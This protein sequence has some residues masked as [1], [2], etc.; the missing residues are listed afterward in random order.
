MT[1]SVGKGR[2]AWPQCIYE[3][4]AVTCHLDE[5][6]TSVNN[7]ADIA[8]RECWRGRWGRSELT[9]DD[10]LEARSQRLVQG[11]CTVEGQRVRA[12]GLAVLACASESN[13][14]ASDATQTRV[15]QVHAIVYRFGWRRSSHSVVHGTDCA[16]LL[17]STPQPLV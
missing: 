13:V 4:T 16:G 7:S 6:Y 15:T 1:S 11:R 14:S 2:E 12:D 5:I 9:R 3:L 17:T 8:P 10:D